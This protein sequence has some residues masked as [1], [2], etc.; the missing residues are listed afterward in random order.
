MYPHDSK[1]VE[2]L[3]SCL[4]HSSDGVT[5]ASPMAAHP[6]DLEWLR[7]LADEDAAKYLLSIAGKRLPNLLY[8]RH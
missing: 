2:N 3:D 1:Y 4:Q 6:L 8:W 7:D 5:L